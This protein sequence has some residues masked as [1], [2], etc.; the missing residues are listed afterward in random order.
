MDAGGNNQI[1]HIRKP[2]TLVWGSTTAF[3][4]TLIR[5][6]RRTG[7]ISRHAL[8][9]SRHG[10]NSDLPLVKA[11]QLT[12]YS[13]PATRIRLLAIVFSDLHQ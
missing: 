12:S 1:L 10:K 8:F 3:L 7:R 11:L 13:I 2:L 9:G 4:T 5:S 6:R